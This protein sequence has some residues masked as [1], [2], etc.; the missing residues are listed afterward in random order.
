MND[1]SNSVPDQARI[2]ADMLSPKGLAIIAVPFI[3]AAVLAEKL[4][5]Q[6]FVVSCHAFVILMLPNML[7]LSRL[8][9]TRLYL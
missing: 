3:E 7:F 8:D 9:K 1:T 2:V 6:G 4:I 5:N